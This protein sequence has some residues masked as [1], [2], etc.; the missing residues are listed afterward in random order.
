MRDSAEID[1]ASARLMTI[2]ELAQPVTSRETYQ[3]G[4]T[5]LNGANAEIHRQIRMTWPSHSERLRAEG[6]I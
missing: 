5:S 6:A 3:R 1:N 4:L 2:Y